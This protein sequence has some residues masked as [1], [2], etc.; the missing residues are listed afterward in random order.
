M[1]AALQVPD[2]LISPGLDEPR[3]AGVTSEEMLAHKGAVLGLVGLEIAIGGRVHEVDE[4]AVAICG[5]ELIPP[6]TP[7]DLDDVPARAAEQALELLDDLAVAAHRAVEALQVAVD[8]ER[9]VVELLASSEGE[10]AH[11]VDLVGL[12]IAEVGV[13]SLLGGV[14]DAAIREVLVE[15]RLVDRV[16]GA[17]AHRHGRELPEPRHEA[18]VRIRGE[19]AAGVRHLLAES[20]KLLLGEPA[21]EECASVHAGGG[22]ALG[23]DLVA[24]A[25]VIGA[26]EEV[27]VAHFVQGR[28][29]GVARDVA[30]DSDAGALRAMHHDCRVPAVDP[31]DFALGRLVAGEP[32]LV[33]GGD[34]VDVVGA[35]KTRDADISLGGAA[36]ERQH[37]VAGSIVA[38]GVDE[39]VERLDP[40]SGFVGIDID[41][42][43]RQSAGDQGVTVTSGGHWM[44]PSVGRPS[45][46]PNGRCAE[47]GM[48]AFFRMHH[49]LSQTG[50]DSTLIRHG[51]G[52][53]R[54]RI[55]TDSAILGAESGRIRR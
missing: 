8:D 12:A 47:T 44:N 26:A 35:A 38:L 33:L 22:V 14:L 34:R 36:Q 40:L 50:G 11:G 25:R 5:E 20:V 30:A 21:L 6:A 18:R 23:E 4:G 16:E 43:G 53:T 41:V 29:G 37:Q 3:G 27:V 45:G 48:V 51:F 13:D 49:A 2:L 31:S 24:A 39:V 46:S 17:Q 1:A 7:D 52:D 42:L 55:R 28:G 15:S 19:S 32:R 54:C 9:E 10:C